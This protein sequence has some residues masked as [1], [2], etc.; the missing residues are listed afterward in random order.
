MVFSLPKRHTALDIERTPHNVIVVDRKN[1]YVHVLSERA[2]GVLEQC[3]GSHTCEQIAR[4]VADNTRS[5]YDGVI[6]EVAHLVGNFA[7]LA[8]IESAALE[9]GAP[10][11]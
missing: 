1:D 11:L 10:R 2:A 5:P 3:D 4:I 6:Q 8:L 9:C 7:D